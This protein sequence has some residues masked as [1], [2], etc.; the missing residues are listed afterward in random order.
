MKVLINKWKS[1]DD[2]DT[3]LEI[4]TLL[5]EPIIARIEDPNDEIFMIELF[6]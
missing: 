6:L 5:T 3:L 1:R 2:N 4:D